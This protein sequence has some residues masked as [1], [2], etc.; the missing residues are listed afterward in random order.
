M[1]LEEGSQATRRRF[2]FLSRFSISRGRPTGGSEGL[3]V[4]MFLGFHLRRFWFFLF[5]IFISSY[6]ELILLY[7]YFPSR[8]RP[9]TSA[10][11]RPFSSRRLLPFKA[12]EQLLLG[13]FHFRRRRG[14]APFCRPLLQFLNAHL[15]LQV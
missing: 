8:C 14:I 15:L 13:R 10:L 4:W 2:S 11:D 7:T 3:P 1:S 6:P 5:W 9:A 12:G